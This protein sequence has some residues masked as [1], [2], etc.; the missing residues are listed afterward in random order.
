MQLEMEG[1]VLE[2]YPQ[3]RMLRVERKSARGHVTKEPIICDAMV[4]TP[5]YEIWFVEAKYE[6]RPQ[7]FEQL[8]PFR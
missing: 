1:K 2:I 3:T 8:S 7:S 6:S 5:D 4:F